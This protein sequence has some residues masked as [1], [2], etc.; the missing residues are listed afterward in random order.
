MRFLFGFVLGLAAGFG[1]TTYMASRQ[2]DQN[3]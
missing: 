3:R 2:Q 1:F